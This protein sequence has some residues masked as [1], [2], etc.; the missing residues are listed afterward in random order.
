VQD[1][2]ECVWLVAVATHGAI[3]DFPATIIRWRRGLTWES[4][5]HDYLLLRTAPEMDPGRSTGNVCPSRT[6]KG[7]T[8]GLGMKWD[9]EVLRE[10]AAV[11]GAV[12]EIS[13]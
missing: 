8:S 4:L 13:T 12:V 10:R 1:F 11:E 6:G 3:D 7:Q 2:Y 5:L 9:F